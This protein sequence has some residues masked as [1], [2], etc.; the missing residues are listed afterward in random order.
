MSRTEE[1][2]ELERL[3]ETTYKGIDYVSLDRLN[4]ITFSIIEATLLD[5]SKS[6][7]LIADKL[8]EEGVTE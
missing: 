8:T 4:A 6:L 7:A 2:K 3:Y 5:I 1:N